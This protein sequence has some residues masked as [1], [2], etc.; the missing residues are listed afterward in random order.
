MTGYMY[1][2]LSQYIP[3]ILVHLP[4]TSIKKLRCPDAAYFITLPAELLKSLVNEKNW[5]H[6]VNIINYFYIFNSN[7]FKYLL[8]IYLVPS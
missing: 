8:L 6:N 7:S 3:N 2:I 5:L 4:L 1:R